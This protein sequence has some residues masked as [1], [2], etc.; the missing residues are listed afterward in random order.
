MIR[1]FMWPLRCM[2]GSNSE[3]TLNRYVYEGSAPSSSSLGWN[4][5]FKRSQLTGL[6]PNAETPRR[7]SRVRACGYRLW[8]QPVGAGMLLPAPDAPLTQRRGGCA[9]SI[10]RL[11][12]RARHADVTHPPPRGARR[13]DV[14]GGLVHTVPTLFGVD[15][16]FFILCGSFCVQR[17][18][19]YV[20]SKPARHTDQHTQQCL[21]TH[22]YFK[23]PKL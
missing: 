5:V 9:S 13:A 2:E 22:F 23:F 21:L 10:L 19:I 1:M 20:D 4:R 6:R 15:G 14:R 17:V 16:S 18:E 12:S 8:H 11:R 3:L 7:S